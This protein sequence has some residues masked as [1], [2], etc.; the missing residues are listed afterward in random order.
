MMGCNLRHH[1]SVRGNVS[2]E[3]T[4]VFFFP[5]SSPQKNLRGPRVNE[6]VW[7]HPVCECLQDGALVLES[8]GNVG[9]FV[10]LYSREF[11]EYGVIWWTEM[12][13]GR[14]ISCRQRTKG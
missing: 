14:S 1:P 10:H 4:A 11:S 6:C 5:P 8:A 12:I 7:G 9:V 3:D 2:D 13:D